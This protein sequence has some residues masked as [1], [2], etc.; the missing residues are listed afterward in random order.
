MYIT[1]KCVVEAYCC[2]LGPVSVITGTTLQG[3]VV[4]ISALLGPCYA[5]LQQKTLFINPVCHLFGDL[6][7]KHINNIW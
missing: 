3:D 1:S 6:P 7:N 4:V 2:P 5:V